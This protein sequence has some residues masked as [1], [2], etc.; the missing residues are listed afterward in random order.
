M[1]FSF[2]TFLIGLFIVAFIGAILIFSGVIKVGKS[3]NSGVV[4]RVTVWGTYPQ[5]IVVP[6]TEKLSTQDKTLSISYT[7]K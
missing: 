5:S 7:E 1:K 4:T 2:Q 3:S 6:Y